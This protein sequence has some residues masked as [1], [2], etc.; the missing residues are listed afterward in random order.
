M[1]KIALELEQALQQRKLDG[2]P[3][4]AAPRKLACGEGWAV[5]DVMC[6]SG[7][8]DRAF[9]ELHSR[10][11]IAVVLAGTFQYRSPA[12]HA[13]MTPGSLLLGNSGQHF[14]CSHD[15][16]EGD[17]CVSF[18]YSPEYFERLLADAGVAGPLDF[19]VP[20]I[21]PVPS[22]APIVAAVGAGIAG[23]SST[24]WEALAIRTAVQAIRLAGGVTAAPRAPRDAEARITE[25]VRDIE[26]GLDGVLSVAALAARAGL[27]PYHFL[28]TFERIT[29][30][31]PHQ[32]VLRARLREAAGRLVEAP[33]RILD[34][35]FDCGFG[36]V[37]NFNRA[38]RTEFGSSP[39]AYCG[40]LRERGA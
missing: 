35:A 26:R 31:T 17:R 3:G 16:A 24:P 32:F 29:G 38:F 14:E 20:R 21:P 4:R 6:T 15:H 18:S 2:T 5:A 10:V 27:S 40:Q 22:A 25:V 39:R 37:S 36:D 9:E 12:G 7:P 19:Q 34:I 11:S 23:G 33:R 30:V 28:R 1:A 8:G 13:T